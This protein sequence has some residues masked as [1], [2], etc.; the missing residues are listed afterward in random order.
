MPGADELENEGVV[1]V[2]YVRTMRTI[3]TRQSKV[4]NNLP[5][6]RSTIMHFRP[7]SLT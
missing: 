1:E 2:K 7:G 5:G 4:S 3:G 6:A